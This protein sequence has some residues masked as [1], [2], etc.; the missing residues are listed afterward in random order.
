[1]KGVGGHGMGSRKRGYVLIGVVALAV[2]GIGALLLTRFQPS[3]LAKRTLR[4]GFQNS[5]PYHFPDSNG[6]PSGPAVDVIRAA[7]HRQNIDL[8]WVFSPEG[9]EKAISSGAVDLWPILG[10]LP[11][12]RR[13]LYISAPWT[14]MTYA[15]VVNQDL[16]LERLEDLGNRSLAVAKISLDSRLAR[17][18]FSKATFVPVPSVADVAE[19]V[20]TGR[21]QAGLISKSAFGSSGN[22]VCPGRALEAISIPGAT[23][24]FGIGAAKGRKDAERAADRLHDEIDTMSSN[25]DLIAIDFRWGTNLS[26]EIATTF[27]Y[28]RTRAN[29]FLLMAACAILFGAV[30]VM[31]L[32]TRRLRLA[33]RQAEAASQ[34]KSEFLANMSHEIR[35]PMNGVI[36]LTEVVL[37]TDL[38]AEQREYLH[39]VKT[40]ADSLLKVINDILDF[41]KIAA[42]KLELDPITFNLHDCIRETIQM[43][44]HR[45]REKHLDLTFD[46]GHGVPGYVVGDPTRLR[47]IIVNLIGNA[48]KFTL[49]GEVS[50]EATVESR[51]SSKL[52]L[53]F[54]IRDTGVGIP[55]EKQEFIFQAFA[56]ADGSTTRQYGGTGLGLSISAQL[57]EMM[58]GKI[59]V[60]GAPGQGSCFHFTVALTVPDRPAHLE[61]VPQGLP[62]RSPVT[63]MPLRILLAE[64]NAVNQQLAASILEKQ[65]HSVIL[66]DNG[67]KAVS[68]LEKRHVDVVLMDVQMP[69]MD[70]L[71]ATALIRQREEGTGKHVPIIALTAHAM[72][73]DKQW[74]LEAGM[75]A[76][77]SKPLHARELV[78]LIDSVCR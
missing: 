75:D 3:A 56:Q 34:A 8:Q 10:D 76:Y 25:G 44:A 55:R 49:Q 12:R 60:E 51:E 69:E 39:C 26:T 5:A 15:L 45:A 46:V 63:S 54:K 65:G 7:A 53:H 23:F 24:W 35:T 19:A 6:N 16:H 32:L 57:V 58:Q 14:A 78:E 28:R 73:N 62:E 52:V 38:T 30:F 48:I 1:M 64:D 18:Y 9:P 41:S 59:W 67:R 72:Q 17:Q 50:L 36:G 11:E 29:A 77:M 4:I 71:E 70:G 74:C 43:L 37:E 22:S 31:V 2:I 21:A 13:L 47:Q 33:R 66:A 68:E 20:C 61:L 27:L 42:G 40:S